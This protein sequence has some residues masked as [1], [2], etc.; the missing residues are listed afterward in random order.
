MNFH[1]PIITRRVFSG[2]LVVAAYVGFQS[3]DTYLGPTGVIELTINSTN[4]PLNLSIG[5]ET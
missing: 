3:N 4:I 2:F 5:L 1:K